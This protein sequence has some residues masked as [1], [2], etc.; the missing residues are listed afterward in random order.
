M[1]GRLSPDDP[2]A[3]ARLEVLA[4]EIHQAIGIQDNDATLVFA[5]LWNAMIEMWLS[6][7]EDWKRRT[8]GEVYPLLVAM[9]DEMGRA[10][11][12]PRG[13]VN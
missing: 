3:Q 9:A 7:P 6:G 4:D 13:L 2:A 8:G 11:R 1:L 5:A 10:A 12:M